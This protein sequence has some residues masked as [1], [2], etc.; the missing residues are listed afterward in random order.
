MTEPEWASDPDGVL[1]RERKQ[2][3]EAGPYVS[4]C[5]SCLVPLL[6]IL[7]MLVVGLAGAVISRLW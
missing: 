2:E 7:L 6:W 5:M 3:E 1:E 4:G